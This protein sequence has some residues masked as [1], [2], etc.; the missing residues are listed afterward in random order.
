VLE[1]INRGLHE[2]VNLQKKKGGKNRKLNL[3]GEETTG[4]DC[5]SPAK[6]AKART[7]LQEKDAITAQEE[8]EK[9]DRKIAKAV[10]ALK[11][12][13][14]R[15]AK[16]IEAQLAKELKAQSLQDPPALKPPEKQPNAKVVKAKKAA[17]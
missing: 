4:I 2:A 15:E 16:A 7:Y 10:N 3:A 14:A 11:N 6:V 12:K 5:Y 1:H 9:E 17:V 8:K 13:E